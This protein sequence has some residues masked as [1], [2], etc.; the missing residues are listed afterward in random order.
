M[1]TYGKRIFVSSRLDVARAPSF[2][3]LWGRPIIGLLH[4]TF[5]MADR[6]K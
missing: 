5:A 6:S 2:Q 1:S 4:L 3:Y